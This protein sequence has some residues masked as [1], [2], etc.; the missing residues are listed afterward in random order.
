MNPKKCLWRK[1]MIKVFI[2]PDIR[3]ALNIVII[4]RCIFNIEAWETL[5][6]LTYL[7]LNTIKFNPF[8]PMFSYYEYFDWTF[9]TC[10]PKHGVPRWL[11][12]KT[13]C[14]PMKVYA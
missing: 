1:N 12:S 3:I 6:C 11:G 13:I 9:K 2:T 10:D 5:Y 4:A 8:N 14:L 7:T